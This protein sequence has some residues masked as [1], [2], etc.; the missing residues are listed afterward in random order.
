LDDADTRR[1][2]NPH[3][4]AG[5]PGAEDNKNLV[6]HD[7]QASRSGGTSFA[8]YLL[9]IFSILLGAITL[10][11]I[12]AIASL[13]MPDNAEGTVLAIGLAAYNPMFLFITASVNNDNLV[14]VLCSIIFW[15]TLLMIRDGFS[16]RRSI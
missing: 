2:P 16:S 13:I 1:V 8:V 5:I 15:Q 9:R 10:R 4:K 6:I 3:V 14:I 12:Y 11:T 7:I